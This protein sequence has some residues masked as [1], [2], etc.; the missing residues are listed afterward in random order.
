MK[1][2][3]IGGTKRGYQTLQALLEAG[4]SICGIISLIQDSHELER[5]EEPIRQLAGD[6]GIPLLETRWMKDR[7]YAA[8]IRDD[9]KPDI[10]LVVGC[11]IMIPDTIYTLPPLGTLAVHDS[12]L[13]KYRGFA[14]LNWVLINGEKETG[15]T[16]FYLNE[17][18][19]GGDLVGQK[20]ILIEP[21]ETAPELYVKI[22]RSTVELV[23]ECWPQ[24]AGETAARTKQDYTTGSFGC[25]RTPVNGMIDW[26]RPTIEIFNLI[27]SLCHPYPGAFTF[28]K[29]KKIII[30]KALPLQNPPRYSGRIPGRVVAISENEGFV[31]VLTV[32]GILRIYSVEHEGREEAASKVITSVKDCLG[33]DTFDLV[34]RIFALEKIIHALACP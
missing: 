23:L 11:R 14:P 18:M 5:Y 21:Y 33:I 7:D 28:L 31:D 19:D 29:G 27:R 26:N 24:L 20:H 6:Y 9:M 16:L 34:N 10:A 4:H 13:P 3:F 2:L 1:T 22:C 15:V 32:G 25:S 17:V 30:R 12:L 8:I